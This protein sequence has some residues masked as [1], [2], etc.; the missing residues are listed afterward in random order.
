MKLLNN[1]TLVCVDCVDS[2]AAKQAIDYCMETFM[3]YDVKLISDET[4]PIKKITDLE[5]YSNFMIK[6]LHR[7]VQSD[8][9]LVVQSDGFIVNPMAWSDDFLNYDYIGAPWWYDDLNVGNGGFSL[10]S[11]KFLNAC[12]ELDLENYF[13]EDDILCRKYRPYFESKGI[14]WPNE[15]TASQFSWEG[16]AK[17]PKYNGSF[18]FHGKSNKRLFV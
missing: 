14:V 3:F 17:Y 2:V 4:Y 5:M 9:C 18:G 8:F 12:K 15:L 10:R 11:K 6:E 1:V 7:Y 16:N 13:P